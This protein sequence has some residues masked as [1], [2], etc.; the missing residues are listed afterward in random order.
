MHPDT[1]ELSQRMLHL[2]D[3]ELLSIVT[4]HRAEYR[5]E[6]ID[7]ASKELR[8]RDIPLP[9][10]NA[11]QLKAAPQPGRS[12]MRDYMKSKPGRVLAT[13]Y[14]LL[15]SSALFLIIAFSSI[16]DKTDLDV[17]GFG[18]IWLLTL[19]W[20]MALILFVYHADLDNPI[21]LLFF[22]LCAGLNAYLINLVGAVF[23]GAS[24]K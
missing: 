1:E 17:Y 7:L 11:H 19:P 5:Q 21:F 16:Y 13:V 9:V 12:L 14:L 2:S 4:A 23:R 6:A 15:A 10:I 24:D 3:D 20:S 18:A 8:Q 22:A